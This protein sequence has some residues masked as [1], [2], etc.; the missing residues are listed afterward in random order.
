MRSSASPPPQFDLYQCLGV[1]QTAT[2]AEIKRAYRKLALK[3]HPDVNKSPNAVEQF[4][5]IQQ[6]YDVLSDDSKR[7][8]YDMR[9]RS[10]SSS[11][12][13]SWN[14][15]ASSS[16][17]NW[18]ASSS[19]SANSYEEA[20]RNYQQKQ[21]EEYATDDSFGSIFSDLLSGLGQGI[22]K[23]AGPGGVVDDLISFLEKQS[24][25]GFGVGEMSK[26]EAMEFEQLLKVASVDVLKSELEDC[27]FVSDQ[28]KSR[29]ERI[30]QQIENQTRLMRNAQTSLDYAVKTEYEA[31]VERLKKREN[32]IVGHIDEQQRRMKRIQD[33]IKIKQAPGTAKAQVESVQRSATDRVKDAKMKI[34]QKVDDELARL[35]KEMGL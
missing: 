2:L 31:E 20:F 10:S 7:R 34:D 18:R 35:K 9:R 4:T 1:E 30:R 8:Q 24:G 11:T 3:S 23:M 27:V 5:R 13:K 26:D 6:A 12:Y 19:S 21:D 29:L 28:L 14:S 32:T 15:S 22:S 25:A 16:S 33:A 17:S